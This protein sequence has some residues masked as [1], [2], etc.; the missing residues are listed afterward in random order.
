[1]RRIGLGRLAV[2][3]LGA[4]IGGGNCAHAAPVRPSFVIILADDMST[5]HMPAMGRVQALLGNTGLTFERAYVETPVCAPTRATLLTGRLAHNHGVLSTAQTRPRMMAVDHDTIASRLAAAGYRTAFLGKYNNGYD[6]SYVP[7]GWQLWRGFCG[8]AP[9]SAV[10]VVDGVRTQVPGH[11][12]DWIRDQASAFIRQTPRDQ[13]FLL[14]ASSVQPHTPHDPARRHRGMFAGAM[15]PRTPAFNEADVSDLPLFLRKP[16]LSPVQIQELDRAWALTLEE[17]QTIDE[18]VGGIIAALQQTG[19]LN[20]TYVVF[21]SDNGAHYGEH[22]FREG[23]WMAFETDIRVPFVVRGPGV[24]ARARQQAMIG[25]VDVPA[26]MLELAGVS[27]SG[28]DGVSF[29]NALR[30]GPGR[31]TA[32]PIAFWTERY[33]LHWRGVRTARHTYAE[34]SA[35]TRLL[36]DNV[37]DPH[38]INNLARDPQSATLLEGLRAQAL[39][40]FTCRGSEACRQ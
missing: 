26:T 40:L 25:M 17:L 18:M 1:M 22:R 7:A 20:N 14:V 37:M 35:S 15:V 28:F 4:L 27:T 36:Y 8:L 2:A 9:T 29:A 21:T 23:K 34:Y 19:R 11:S 32:M 33:Q 30:G 38:Q 5:A 12:D 39:R 31:R 13:P 16:L 3:V 6:C 10:T 24:P